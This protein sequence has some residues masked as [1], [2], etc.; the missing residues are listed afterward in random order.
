MEEVHDLGLVNGKCETFRG[1]VTSSIFLFEP[2]TF[3]IKITRVV[4]PPLEF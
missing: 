4:N 1:G 2:E 3:T